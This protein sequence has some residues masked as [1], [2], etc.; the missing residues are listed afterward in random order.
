MIADIAEP[1]RHRIAG[2]LAEHAAAARQLTDRRAGL[3]V[4]PGEY[5]PFQFVAILVEDAKGRI[6]GARQLTR[7]IDHFAQHVLKIKLGDETAAD[8]D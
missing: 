3:L 6:S 5:E 2:Q 7:N 1:Q 4:D 8:I